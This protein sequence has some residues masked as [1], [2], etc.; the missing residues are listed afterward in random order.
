MMGTYL[1]GGELAIL[2]P[3]DRYG[4][5]ARGIEFLELALLEHHQIPQRRAELPAEV[6]LARGEHVSG[7]EREDIDKTAIRDRPCCPPPLELH[8]F[9]MQHQVIP[10]ASRAASIDTRPTH[11]RS[12][13][14]ID[15][16][17]PPLGATEGVG[18][19]VPDDGVH[20][21]PH[22]LHLPFSERLRQHPCDM[23]TLLCEL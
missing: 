16:D 3:E 15:P 20:I 13:T 22:V 17:D 18:G 12:V 21:I 14:V 11:Q 4:V 2:L 10:R 19:R 6:V 7:T 9:R 23:K 8:S 5:E 1:R